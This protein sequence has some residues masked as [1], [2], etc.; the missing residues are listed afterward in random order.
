[1]MK[2]YKV[3]ADDIDGTQFGL[4][5]ISLVD[6]PAV[7]KNFVAFSKEDAPAKIALSL[8]EEKRIISGVALLADTPIYRKMQG[9]CYIVFEKETIRQLVLKYSKDGLLNAITLQHDA[10]TYAVNKC[11]MVESYFTDKERGIAPV[12]FSDIPDGSWCVTFK[13]EDEELW[14]AIKASHGEENG[15]NG[16]SIEAFVPFVEASKD[17]PVPEEYYNQFDEISKL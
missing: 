8:D 15:L 14:R 11:V 7:E 13:V 6:F 4:S 2:I 16:F 10:D 17:E 12:A 9:G 1:M 5:A 3:N